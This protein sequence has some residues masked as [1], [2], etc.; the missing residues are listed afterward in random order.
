M[1]TAR[2]GCQQRIENMKKRFLG[3]GFLALAAALL[4]GPAVR[5][6]TSAPPP[7]T[8]DQQEAT[9][10]RRADREGLRD[11]DLSNDQKNQIGQIRQNE[12]QQLEAVKNDPSLTPAQK[13]QKAKEIRRSSNKQISGILTPEQRKKWNKLRRQ[14]RR[15][16]R[17]AQFGRPRP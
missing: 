13:R 15:N 2:P 1:A 5:A 4:S 10:P 11:L 6:Q 17:R 12:K 14:N 3:C 8:G 7:Q 9:E 16:R